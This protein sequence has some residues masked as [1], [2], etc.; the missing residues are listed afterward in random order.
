MRTSRSVPSGRQRTRRDEMCSV[1][2][3][4]CN[5]TD[6]ETA[7]SSTRLR[8]LGI[9][10]HHLEEVLQ[11]LLRRP[12]HYLVSAATQDKSRPS[13]IKKHRLLMLN[14]TAAALHW[15][16]LLERGAVI[17]SFD[18]NPIYNHR[19]PDEGEC[20]LREEARKKCWGIYRMRGKNQHNPAWVVFITSLLCP[21]PHLEGGRPQS[22]H[23]CVWGAELI[24][25]RPPNK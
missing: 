3:R 22:W 7:P 8:G 2:V 16:V 1:G 25:G 24:S 15:F 23:S 17:A 20:R 13:L 5:M 18:N 12:R 4:C 21:L 19:A 10:P 11:N 6:R 9:Q 14:A